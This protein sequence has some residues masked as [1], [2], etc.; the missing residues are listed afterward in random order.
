[1]GELSPLSDFLSGSQLIIFKIE[2]RPQFYTQQFCVLLS[3]ISF[4]YTTI[5]C[6]GI[7]EVYLNLFSFSLFP[8]LNSSKKEINILLNVCA[9]K[10]KKNFHNMSARNI[11]LTHFRFLLK[12]W[13]FCSFFFSPPFSLSLLSCSG[14]GTKCLADFSS[15]QAQSC[16]SP[17]PLQPCSSSGVLGPSWGCHDPSRHDHPQ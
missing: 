13:P 10:G 2:S 6:I 8:L 1:M 7:I 9:G 3:K 4:L 12:N 15:S 16:P 5:S 14:P 17:I 11:L